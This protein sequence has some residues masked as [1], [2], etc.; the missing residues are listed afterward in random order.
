MTALR[1]PVLVTGAAG[2]IGRRLVAQLIAQGARVRALLLEQ[3]AVP[4]EWDDRV[5]IVRGDVTQPRSVAKAMSGV[6]SVFH[7][8]ALV[9]EGNADY[10]G[11]W[12][13]TAEG[14]RN[15]Y[16]A[17]TTAKARVIVTTSVCAY[18]D[19]IQKGVC[20]EADER[21]QFQGPYGRAK[22]AQED[23]ALEAYRRRKLA[24][25]IVRP[26]NVYGI[27]CK[28][29]VD[30]PTAMLRMGAMFV[31]GDGSGNA[32]LVHVDNLVDALICIATHDETI[33][34]IYNVCDGHDVTW[35][36]YMDDLADIIGAPKPPSVEREA[37]FA[38]AHANEDPA[39]LVGP[40]DASLPLEFLNLLGSDNRFDTER[41]RELG[42]SPRV[43][44][45]H[46]MGEIAAALKAQ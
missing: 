19:A 27:G 42:W 39:A 36:R 40:G 18:G 31:V 2:F 1:S 8:A 22:Q 10:P 14:S 6:R 33:G 4:S 44:Y 38:A 35:R 9:A 25:S 5:E 20:G 30:I 28:P 16:D 7:L 29:W 43:S 37:L 45:E 41:L 12:A 15:V 3:E 13:V 26:S 23:L 17:A 34:G 32:G 21:G 46:A 24:V 11:H